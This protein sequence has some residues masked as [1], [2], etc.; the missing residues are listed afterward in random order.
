MKANVS[1]A[2]DRITGFVSKVGIV[3]SIIGMVGAEKVLSKN[4][5]LWA[6]AYMVCVAQ[7]VYAASEEEKDR[8]QLIAEEVKA[9]VK[10]W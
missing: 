2:I 4:F 7:A 9:Q 10:G 5:A 3:G 8:A 1:C 6:A